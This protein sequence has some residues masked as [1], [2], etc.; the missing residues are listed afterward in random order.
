VKKSL[1]Y[2][3]FKTAC[4]NSI[5]LC[6]K[7]EKTEIISSFDALNRVVSKD[8]ICI[9]NLPSFDNSAIDGYAIK[10]EDLGKTLKITHTIFAGDKREFQALKSGE[11]YKIMT[12]AKVSKDI[13]I[14]VPFELCKKVL[15]DFIEVPQ[16]IKKGSNIRLKGEEQTIG[17]VILK[18]GTK[19]NSSHLAILFSQG[20]TAL[21]VYKKLEIAI[22][23]TGDELK[24]PWEKAK[25]DEIYNINSFFLS[26]FL[27][28]QGFNSS[29]CGLAPDSLEKSIELIDGL[30]DFDLI[31]TS[32]GISMGDADFLASAFTKCGLDIA[33]HGVNLKPGKAMM[34]G[35]I[36]KTIVVAL[37]GNPLASAINSYLFLLPI[38]KKLQGE[39][40]FYHDFIATKNQTNF[41]V[42]ED[43]VEAVLGFLE[44]GVFKAVKNNKYGSGMITL[45]SQ[46]NALA[47]FDGNKTSINENEIIKVL[48]F[49]GKFVK[50]KIDFLN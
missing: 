38:L 30:K 27:K 37:P 14:I 20:I 46:S 17:N 26:S 8:I 29:Y 41:K 31:I 12:G 32:G 4:E 13:D 21:E 39:I 34:M 16:D 1:K 15:E 22:I 3:D 43:R 2:L 48:E 6:K 36:N 19:L 7:I 23:S 42:K 10:F 28:E 35:N 47:L 9:K 45:L 5:N 33:Y 25:E 50:E 18:K 11:C 44:F 24:E 49:N 40:F